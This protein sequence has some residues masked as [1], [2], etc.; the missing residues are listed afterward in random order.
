[1]R[2]DLARCRMSIHPVGK[3]YGLVPEGASLSLLEIQN[4]LAIER[5]RWRVFAPL[6]DPEWLAVGG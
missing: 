6:V 4:E 3:S 1:M 2:E 5:E